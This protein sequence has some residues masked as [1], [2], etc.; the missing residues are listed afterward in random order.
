M[1][2]KVIRLAYVTVINYTTSSVIQTLVS[3]MVVAGLESDAGFGRIVKPIVFPH[4][5]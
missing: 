3:R 2:T 5:A 4:H 1:M